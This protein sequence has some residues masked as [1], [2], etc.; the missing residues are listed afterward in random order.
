[1]KKI[2]TSLNEQEYKRFKKRVA[3]KGISEYAFVKTLV[4]K[5]LS[6]V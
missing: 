3:S 6:D 5:E 2:G 1:M 4:L